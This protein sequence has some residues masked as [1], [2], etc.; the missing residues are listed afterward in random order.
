MGGVDLAD[1]L[2]RN[3]SFS[4]KSMRWY[5]RVFWFLMESA[6]VNAHILQ[7]ETTGEKSPQIKFRKALVLEL[8]GKFDAR[9]RPGRQSII[10]AGRY[11]DRHFP[12]D[13][14]GRGRCAVQHCSKRTQYYCRDCEKYLRPVPCF[15]IWHTR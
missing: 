9:K 3:Y 11:R 12:D 13:S 2:R 7:M 15:R 5:M 6:L 4:L 10:S 8:L 1:N 14:D